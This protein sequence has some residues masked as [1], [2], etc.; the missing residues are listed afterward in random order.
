M[1]TA[2][3]VEDNTASAGV[4]AH[5]LEHKGFDVLITIDAAQAAH[6]CDDF[7]I[8]ILIADVILRSA[9][10]GADIAWNIRQVSPDVPVLFVSGTPLEGWS[11]PDFA[12]I[13]ALLPGRVNFLGKPF[14]AAALA[15]T[16]ASLLHHEYSD[17][18]I[19]AA[20]QTARKFRQVSR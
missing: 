2:L 13:E 6:Y 16:V 15:S 8:D 17:E 14:T 20:I 18:S 4:L 7:K 11:E 19:R 10:S 1:P 3:V 5:V 9:A 12:R